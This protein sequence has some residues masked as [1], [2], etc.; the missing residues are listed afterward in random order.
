MMV[1]DNACFLMEFWGVCLRCMRHESGFG[2]DKTR[3][4]LYHSWLFC[5]R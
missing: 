4:G 3:H 1:V 5:A 2:D